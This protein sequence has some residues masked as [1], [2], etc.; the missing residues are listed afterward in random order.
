MD[1]AVYV[2]VETRANDV[3]QIT[4]YDLGPEY[5]EQSLE[6]IESYF[7]DIPSFRGVAIHDY[8]AYKQALKSKKQIGI[9]GLPLFSAKFGY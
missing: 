8:E 4:F 2:G 7:K 9:T 1:K 5:L 6:Q 3:E